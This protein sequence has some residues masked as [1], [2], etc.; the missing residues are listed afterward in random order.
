M[1]ILALASNLLRFLLVLLLLYG[2]HEDHESH[3]DDESNEGD[4]DNEAD[5]GNEG[6]GGHERCHPF[7]LQ[8]CPAPLGWACLGCGFGY[9]PWLGVFRLW[10]WLGMFR[11]WTRV[12][13]VRPWTGLGVQAMD[14]VG[15][16]DVVDLV[17]HV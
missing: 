13:M 5:E 11:P 6:D 4:E 10:I 8:D 3:E 17:E 2:S 16:V 7:F 1:A 12:A 15:H 14:F 9:P